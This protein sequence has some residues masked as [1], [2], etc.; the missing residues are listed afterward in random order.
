MLFACRYLSLHINSKISI[1]VNIIKLAFFTLII[2]VVHPIQSSAQTKTDNPEEDRLAIIRYDKIASNLYINDIYIDKANRIRVSTSD[3][4]Y[5][6]SNPNDAPEVMLKGT[7]VV[8]SVVDGKGKVYAATDNILW[9]D[10][11][12]KS[13]DLRSNQATISSLAV[14]NNRIWIGT[15]Q[16]IMIYNPTTDRIDRLNQENSALKT[17]IINFIH[18]DEKEIVWI[19]TDRGEYRIEEEKWK[20]YNEKYNVLSFYENSEGIWFLAADDMWLV[21][22]YNRQYK[23]GLEKAMYSGKVNDFAIDSR[24][25]LYVASDKLLRYDP[26]KE[27]YEDFEGDAGI[28]TSK[29]TRIAC[30]KNDNIWVG[31]NGA[32]LYR[33]AFKDLVATQFNVSILPQKAVSCYGKADASIKI[34]VTGGKGPFKYEWNDPRLKGP[35]P[36]GIA[37]GEYAVTV[38]DQIQNRFT[39][40]IIVDQPE[41]IVINLTDS[42]RVSAPNSRDG[43]LEISATGGTGDLSYRWSTGDKTSAV[44]KLKAGKYTISV[45]DANRCLAEAEFSVQ[46]EKFIPDLEI[47]KINVGTV[48]RINALYFK[49]DSTE[50][51]PESFDVLNEV[52]DFLQKN[53][54]VSIEIGGHT[55]TVPPHE[56]CD[57]LS[58]DRAKN[59]AKFFYENKIPESRVSYKGYG[60]RQPITQSESIEGRRL[61]QRVEIKV[62]S[63]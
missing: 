1:K 17:N 40:S 46:R 47:S 49:A 48:L 6:I 8:A 51:T 62:L 55:N 61:N 21:D 14:V 60:K 45:T 39:S 58:T 3:G 54:N 15:N 12:Q 56:Y 23:V 18:Q 63:I 13:I 4:L 30:D 50:V 31:T 53:Q 36:S 19:G 44:S 20:S 38:T 7:K 11:N 52:L 33:L 28:V 42:K 41:P 26:Y 43:S 57:K 35:N 9:I 32:G 34:N 59:V 25:R 2:G 10:E 37:A 29:C 24:G 27:Q 5:T 16:G 22:R